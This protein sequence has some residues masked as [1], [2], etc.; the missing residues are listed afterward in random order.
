MQRHLIA[1]WLH[2][3]SLIWVECHLCMF[4]CRRQ[5]FV[6]S[7][8]MRLTEE[9]R[10]SMKRKLIL[11]SCGA[12]R[13]IQEFPTKGWKKTT[14]IDFQANW[15]TLVWRSAKAAAGWARTA[16]THENINLLTSLCWARRTHH[17]L[18]IL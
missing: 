15:E 3:K 16:H 4:P 1:D 17:S 7:R 9:D 18:T 11:K 14:L 10:I 6:N 5:M 13:L 12:K 2:L 8:I